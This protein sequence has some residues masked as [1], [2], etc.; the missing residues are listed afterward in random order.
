MCSFFLLFKKKVLCDVLNLH[1][2]IVI[3]VIIVFHFV[4]TLKHRDLSYVFFPA[5]KAI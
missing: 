5:H 4:L 1:V 2:D 3:I